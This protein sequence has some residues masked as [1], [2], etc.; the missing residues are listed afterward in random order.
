[1][2]LLVTA[3]S[4]QS[5]IVRAPLQVSKAPKYAMIGLQIFRESSQLCMVT[6]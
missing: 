2:L 3:S 6:K 4:A 5:A 1:M